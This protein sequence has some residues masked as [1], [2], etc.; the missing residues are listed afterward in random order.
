M[1]VAA[2]VH[3]SNGSAWG[4]QKCGSRNSAGLKFCLATAAS[5]AAGAGGG[6]G[7]VLLLLLA[8][9]VLY[10][11]WWWRRRYW[12]VV[13]PLLVRGIEL[14]GSAVLVPALLQKI[15]AVVLASAA[16]VAR[17]YSSIDSGGEPELCR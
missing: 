5:V 14:V 16:L 12:C 3:G 10:S 7:T 1:P 11:Y 8:V 9:V 2:T 6:G 13:A 17:Y 15:V 4:K